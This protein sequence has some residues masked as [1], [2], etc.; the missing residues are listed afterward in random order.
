M[1]RSALWGGWGL[2]LLC[3]TCQQNNTRKAQEKR[4]SMFFHVCHSVQNFERLLLLFI[5]TSGAASYA[6]GELCA[7]VYFSLRFENSCKSGCFVCLFLNTFSE[8]GF[9]SSNE[10]NVLPVV[11]FVF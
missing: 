7:Y 8:Y 10:S 6:P 2:F 4:N 9:S 11:Q 3:V 5:F 1:A